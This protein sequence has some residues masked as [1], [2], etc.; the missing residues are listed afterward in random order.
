MYRFHEIEPQ[1]SV[2]ELLRPSQLSRKVLTPPR[3]AVPASEL[4]SNTLALSGKGSAFPAPSI[5]CT[6]NAATALISSSPRHPGAV[7]SVAVVSALSTSCVLRLTPR[8][9]IPGSRPPS[10]R[11]CCQVHLVTLQ[12]PDLLLPCAALR[13]LDGWPPLCLPATV[14]CLSHVL[15]LVIAAQAAAAAVA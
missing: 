4:A 6:R 8:G 2:M 12:N 14:V 7:R 9:C 3:G 13:L 11:S 5:W 10:A 1:S 15:D